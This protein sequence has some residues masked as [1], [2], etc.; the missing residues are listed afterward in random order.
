M[1]HAVK[2]EKSLIFDRAEG[3]RLWDIHG[4]EYLD[5][6]SGSAGPAMVG[7]AHPAVA[8]AVARQMAKLPSTNI[9]HESVPVIE[10]CR[11]LAEIAPAGL[12]KTFICT[13]GGEAIEAAIKFA[14]HVTGRAEVI[15]LTGAYHGMSLATMGLTGMPAMR[16]TF[17]IIAGGTPSASIRWPS[18]R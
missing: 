1:L 17:S 6:M 14:I 16:P 10:F 3:S 2:K 11:R 7:H 5:T 12:T 4:K 8:D 13:G 9:L 15:S 18:R